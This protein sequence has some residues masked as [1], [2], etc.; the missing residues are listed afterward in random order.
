MLNCVR[1]AHFIHTPQKGTTPGVGAPKGRRM[2]WAFSL[3]AT[4]LPA[5][6]VDLEIAMPRLGDAR[7]SSPVDKS[8]GL[9]ASERETHIG[10]L[11]DPPDERPGGA[12]I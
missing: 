9:W 3:S 4:A 10:Y 11:T 2:A 5:G 12:R 6:S 7:D 1:M 8:P